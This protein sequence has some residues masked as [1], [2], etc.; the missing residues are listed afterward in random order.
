MKTKGIWNY[1]NKLPL[2][3][4]ETHIKMGLVKENK[5]INFLEKVLHWCILF[6]AFDIKELEE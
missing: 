2:S 3:K 4:R 6:S 1:Y 5:K